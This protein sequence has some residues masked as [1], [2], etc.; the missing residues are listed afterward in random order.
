MSSAFNEEIKK[1]VDEVLNDEQTAAMIGEKVRACVNDAIKD[2]FR[3]G[4]LE[5]A[6]KAKIS[7]VLVPY[8]ENY[9]MG[10]FIPKLDMVLTDLANTKGMQANK[11]ILENFKQLM[12]EDAP[13][14][15]DISEI[16]ERYKKFATHDMDTCG[17]E[18]VADGGDDP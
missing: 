6:I 12:I 7:E 18:V 9:D 3:W 13:N 10:E 17:R 4:D 2:A 8:I 5:K 16:W 11:I 14:D 15:V 1:T